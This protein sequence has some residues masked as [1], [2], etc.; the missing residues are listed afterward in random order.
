MLDKGM[1]VLLIHTFQR[2]RKQ[3]V[4]EDACICL[5]K[6]CS[7]KLN[8][9][10]V[11]LR[12][13]KLLPLVMIETMKENPSQV[14]QMFDSWQE[15]P[16]L[17]WNKDSQA[18]AMEVSSKA[19]TNIVD[20]LK[21]DINTYWKMPDDIS[22][23][24]IDDL[25]VGGVYLALFMKQPNWS[26]RK[27]RDFL[28]AILEKFVELSSA[29]EPNPEILELVADAAVSFLSSQKTM[30]DYIVAL[31]YIPKIITMCDKGTPLVSM[32]TV[33][34]LHEIATS[35]PCVESMGA[36][37]DVVAS[38]MASL[39]H[40][41]DDIG[42]I[43]DTMERLMSRSSE[44]ANMVKLAVANKIPQKLLAMLE[45]GMTNAAQPPAARAIIVKV[46]KAIIANNDPIY[47]PQV[48]SVL[49]QSAVW[50]KYKSQSHELFLTGNT[51]GGYITGPKGG[52]AANGGYLSLAAPPTQTNDS[53]PP[54]LDE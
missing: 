17:V 15:N 49:S 41:P 50:A 34:V 37:P 13:A 52:G 48:E 18:R 26:V 29:A 5:A 11:Q 1:Y 10:K 4:K 20:C 51:F 39:R 6:A 53:E 46:L 14:C 8:G 2:A 3:E 9:P 38:L 32:C 43:M 45:T 44:K 40:A 36:G 19:R 27:P 16:E 35:K 24:S 12:C 33:R 47:G 30:A 31:G 54:P 22:T 7:D 23:P 21:E 28:M 25:Q 42:L